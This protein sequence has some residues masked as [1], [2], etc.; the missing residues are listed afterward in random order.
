[1]TK[2]LHQPHQK[3]KNMKEHNI[4]ISTTA[5]PQVVPTQV[6]VTRLPQGQ[7]GKFGAPC[8][9]GTSQA[10][11]MAV[12]SQAPGTPSHGVTNQAP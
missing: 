5:S 9:E 7:K 11:S 6:T 3:N 2:Q 12:T 8:Q 10:P 4:A 1:M